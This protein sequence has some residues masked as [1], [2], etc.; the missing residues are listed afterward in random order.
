MGIDRT[1]VNPYQICTSASRPTNATQGTLIYE[2]DTNN[3]RF[4]N[5]SNWQLFAGTSRILNSYSATTAATRQD[6]TSS[7]WGAITGL[8][9]TL[10]PVSTASKFILSA[11]VLHS[12]TYVT[13]FTFFKGG[14][15]LFSHANTNETGALATQYW[16]QSADASFLFPSMFTWLDSPA[17]GSSI[18]YDVRGT[19]SWAGGTYTLR[20]NDRSTDM[21]GRS[22]FMIYEVAG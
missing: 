13:S 9:I 8:S 2:T 20:I 1:S 22:H 17:T 15:N 6:I 12:A 18:T 14:A 19:S 5:G 10:T 3:I 11:Y 21:L 4:Y 16:G 7:T